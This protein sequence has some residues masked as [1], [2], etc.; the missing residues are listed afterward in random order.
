MLQNRVPESKILIVDDNPKNLEILGKTLEN[1]KH[2]VEFVVDGEAALEWI[3]NEL[4]ARV[5]T[6]LEL[7][8]NREKLKSVNKWHEDK[9]IDSFE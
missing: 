8:H 5:S 7:R 6:Q 9:V 1:Q 2:H 4:L 3:K